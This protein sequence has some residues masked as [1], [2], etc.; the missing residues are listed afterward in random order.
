MLA[1]TDTTNSGQVQT[2]G[3]DAL[4]RLTSASTDQAGDAATRYS[5]A[6]SYSPT[7]NFSNFDGRTYVYD[8]L[9]PHAVR[10][11]YQLNA[12]GRFDDFSTSPSNWTLGGAQNLQVP[13]SDS[14]ENVLRHG[15][16]SSTSTIYRTDTALGAGDAL[17]VEF[18]SDTAN[19]DL[20]LLVQTTGSQAFGLVATPGTTP[21]LRVYS[22]VTGQEY[23]QNCAWT[24]A[25]DTWYV[26][27]ITV[28]DGTSSNK[29]KA[30][31]WK[32]NV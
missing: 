9:H 31:V 3:Y 24:L 26:L 10:Y 29:F 7:G 21:R 18:K 6:Y 4:D 11:A 5:D 14:G 12:G 30:L 13:Y 15:G 17:Q 22:K 25:A 19:A 16:N 2:F 27:R 20:K 28:G 32:R 8:V 1:I 23:W